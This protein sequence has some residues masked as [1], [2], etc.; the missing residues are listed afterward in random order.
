MHNQ[1]TITLFEYQRTTHSNPTRT[2]VS[3]PN[4][5]ILSGNYPVFT[6]YK[7]DG[8]YQFGNDIPIIDAL[9]NAL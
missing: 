6:D 9:A 8:F 2:Y 7:W 1:I 4:Q 5:I 3:V